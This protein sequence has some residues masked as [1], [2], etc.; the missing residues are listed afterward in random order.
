V[1]HRGASGCRLHDD[2]E[3]TSLGQGLK[4]ELPL[5]SIGFRS[6]IVRLV[7]VPRPSVTFEMDTLVW[8]ETSTMEPWTRRLRGRC[9][10]LSISSF[11]RDAFL[12]LADGSSFFSF[13][14]L[15]T[16]ARLFSTPR[17]TPTIVRHFSRSKK[18]LPL[19]STSMSTRVLFFASR[20]NRR[21]DPRIRPQD[22]DAFH[23]T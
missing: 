3:G 15:S 10:F 7:L 5:L 20:L 17:T 1:S 23:P 19:T 11:A 4:A 13:G 16:P 9:V 6:D 8:T 14:P 2:D 12:R 18:S 21:P 22:E